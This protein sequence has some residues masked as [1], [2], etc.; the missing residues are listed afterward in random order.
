[1]AR[2]VGD[3]HPGRTE[4]RGGPCT[5]TPTRSHS[6]SRRQAQR[7]RIDVLE[8]VCRRPERAPRG[9]FSRRRDPGGALLPPPAPRPGTPGLAGARPLPALQG[10]RRSDPLRG[11]GPSRL[12][13]GG[14]AGDLPALPDA[15]CEGHPDRK[16]PGVE[17]VAG[18]L[19][20]GVAVGAGMAWALTRGVP[21][22]SA[23]MRPVGPGRARPASTSCSAT[24]SSTPAS[25]GRAR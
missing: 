19:G 2:A 15:A 13:P 22:P 10:P 9:P 18:P 6:T 4:T 24:A 5:S 25:S 16:L 17:M 23:A 14:G 1:M 8:M 20:H 11:A 12:L 7:L 3:P 21:K